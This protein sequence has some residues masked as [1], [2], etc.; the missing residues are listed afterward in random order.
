MTL[1]FYIYFLSIVF[2]FAGIMMF[3]VNFFLLGNIN[4]FNMTILSSPLFYIVTGLML[5]GGYI[6]IINKN[7]NKFFF[8]IFL[9]IILFILIIIYYTFIGIW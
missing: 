7:N 4:I 1:K 9:L 3:I 5:M 8:N 6:L 2:L